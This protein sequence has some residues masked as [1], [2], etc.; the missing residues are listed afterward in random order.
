M[1]CVSLTHRADALPLISV[2]LIERKLVAMG[3]VCVKAHSCLNTVHF[4]YF[5]GDSTIKCWW[6][7][8]LAFVYV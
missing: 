2:F 6:H 3:N 1:S 8:I 5:N 7:C 4:A